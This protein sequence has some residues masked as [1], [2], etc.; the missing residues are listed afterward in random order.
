MNLSDVII[1]V[2]IELAGI[3]IIFSYFEIFLNKGN[4]IKHICM[5][6]IAFAF[7]TACY[8][9]LDINIINF[10]STIIGVLIIS[11]AF[12]GEAKSKV[13]LSMLCCSI[14]LTIDFVVYF[15][16]LDNYNEYVYNVSVSFLSVLFFYIVMMLLKCIFIKKMK[17]E[18]MGQW[19]ILFVVSVMSVSLLI[20][21]YSG[22]NISAYGMIYL[23]AMLLVL[24]ILLYVFYSN[25]LDRYVYYK[26]NEQLKQQMN[27]YEQQ[28]KI[29]VE[30]DI[31]IRSIRHDIKHHIREINALADKGGLEEI[32]AYTSELTDDIKQSE[33]V[34]NTGNVTFD[35]VLNYYNSIFMQ[36]NIHTVINVVIPETLA[37]STYDLNIILGNLFDNAVEN[38]VKSVNPKVT[39]DIN[40]VGH[41][42][43]ISVANT[44]DGMIKKDKDVIISRKG[45]DHGYGL[46][47]IKR[48]VEKYNGDVKIEYSGEMFIVGV[49]VYV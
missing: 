48:I 40:Y 26:E 24:N 7:T 4:K 27:M 45:A 3:F 13:L 23:S 9:I 46:D 17:T 15:I 41:I 10:L 12:E 16:H 35:G 42:L 22:R 31:K 44:Y 36:K 1:S 49:V 20:G 29:N 30:N 37:I 32:K 39:V 5:N 47:N 8:L 34:Y 28:L 21:L 11:M 33:N 19:Y 6:V 25:M 18:F 38:V 2:I 43:Y 14:M